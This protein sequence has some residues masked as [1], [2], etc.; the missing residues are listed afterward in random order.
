MNREIELSSYDPD[1]TLVILV[2]DGNIRRLLQ[3]F[4][5]AGEIEKHEYDEDNLTLVIVYV[6]AESALKS[7][8]MIVNE[9]FIHM[10]N[11]CDN[12]DVILNNF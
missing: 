1:R 4:E 6:K 9:Q 8:E 12:I 2:R 10:K 3:K 5:K 11:V 7:T